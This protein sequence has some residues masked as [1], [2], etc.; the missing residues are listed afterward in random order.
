MTNKYFRSCFFLY[1]LNCLEKKIKKISALKISPSTIIIINRVANSS[2][3][4]N[5]NNNSSSNNNN[6]NNNNNN[7]NIQGQQQSTTTAKQ[8]P[9]V[10]TYFAVLF[11][12][13]R[14]R[15]LPCDFVFNGNNY[16]VFHLI[17]RY[18]ILG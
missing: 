9:Y 6:N 11:D 1:Y 5:N 4:S 14:S 15:Y 16:R 7:I 8:R 13:V 10:R 17:A 18:E 12:D 2:S 3:S